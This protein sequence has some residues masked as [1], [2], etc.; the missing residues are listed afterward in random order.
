[1]KKRG[2]C[3][4]AREPKNI[5]ILKNYLMYITFI[6]EEMINTVSFDNFRNHVK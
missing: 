2:D 1:M 6:K 4:K 3:W 5:T